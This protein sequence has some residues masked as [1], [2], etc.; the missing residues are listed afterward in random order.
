MRRSSL[1][2]R[3]VTLAVAACA[4]SAAAHA[5]LVRS[6][7]ADAPV[8]PDVPTAVTLRF[9]AGIE[10]KLSRVVLLNARHA[11]QPLAVG[12]GA[13]AGEM[14]VQVPALGPGSYGLKYRVMAA[15]GHLTDGTVRFT[16][17]AAR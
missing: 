16:I 12:P 14:V 4:G 17:A 7:L 15:D 6:S 11:E 3:L 1:I 8:R 13:Q 10:V 9:N 5:I 2:A